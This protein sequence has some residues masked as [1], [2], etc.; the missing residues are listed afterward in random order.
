MWVYGDAS[1]VVPTYFLLPHSGAKMKIAD[2]DTLIGHIYDGITEPKPW[3]TFVRELRRSLSGS[4]ASLQLYNY[5]LTSSRLSISDSDESIDMGKFHTSFIRHY[6]EAASLFR[7]TEPGEIITSS[8]V[9]SRA[10]LESTEVYK[11]FMQPNDLGDVI[12]FGIETSGNLRAWL[13]VGRSLRKPLFD[14]RDKALCATLSPHLA[15]AVSLYSKLRREQSEKHVYE[16]LIEQFTVGMVL[17]DTNGEIIRTNQRAEKIISE[18]DS[19]DIRNRRLLIRDPQKGKLFQ[20]AVA[21][22]TSQRSKFGDPVSV[23]AIGVD[24]HSNAVVGVIVKSIPESRWTAGPDTPVSIVCLFE[25][26]TSQNAKRDFICQ[27]F[28]LTPAEANLAILLADGVTLADAASA[29]NV[30][31]H[32]TRAVSKR[33]FSKLGVN[34]QQDLVRIIVRCTSMLA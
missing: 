10:G 12:K 30:S 7:P 5:S 22:A 25:T 32:T 31:E 4:M 17:L 16:A 13:D 20:A 11:R 3:L 9:I 34:R 6:K 19:I 24:H 18:S 1:F 2:T 23:D 14:E 21:R 15:R 27:V 8:D 33:I 26:D 28:A 29:L